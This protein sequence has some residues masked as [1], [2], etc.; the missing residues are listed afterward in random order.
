MKYMPPVSHL[1]DANLDWTKATSASD[2]TDS[3]SLTEVAVNTHWAT[4]ISSNH[5]Q[6]DTT[7]LS[8]TPILH[9]RVDGSV[10]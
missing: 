1:C 9:P 2:V 3:S 10:F 8:S 4:K 7:G 5:Q 6:G